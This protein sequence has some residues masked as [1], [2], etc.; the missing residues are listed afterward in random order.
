[1]ADWMA[2]PEDPAGTSKTV[3]L[4][5][6]GVA[7]MVRGVTAIAA[8]DTVVSSIETWRSIDAPASIV[9]IGLAT[10]YVFPIDSTSRP[11]T[12]SVLTAT[13]GPDDVRLRI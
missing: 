8:G 9:S 1:M 6:V 12:Q 7:G 2:V 5:H 4:D 10:V 13:T 11:G 3:R